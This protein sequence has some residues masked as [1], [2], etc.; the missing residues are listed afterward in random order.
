LPK[1]GD[2]MK[3]RMIAEQSGEALLERLTGVFAG[4]LPPP[5][6][7]KQEIQPEWPMHVQVSIL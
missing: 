3:L 7:P 1:S 6:F 2:E 5:I 4:I